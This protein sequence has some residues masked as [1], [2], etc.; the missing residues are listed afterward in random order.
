MNERDELI[1]FFDKLEERNL[2]GFPLDD[3][4]DEPDMDF[5]IV[6]KPT[7]SKYIM[8]PLNPVYAS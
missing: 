5:E 8:L 2:E 1:E 7:K 4:D 6:Q 3:S